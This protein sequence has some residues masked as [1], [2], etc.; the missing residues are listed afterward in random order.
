MRKFLIGLAVAA[1][2]VSAA[3]KDYDLE[4]VRIDDK[5]LIREWCQASWDNAV[6]GKPVDIAGLLEKYSYLS[7][8]PDLI[9]FIK[10]KRDEAKDPVERRR[11]HYFYRD[12]AT[13]Y[14]AKRVAALEDE[15]ENRSASDHIWVNGFDEPVTIR[16]YYFMTRETDD[17]D[18]YMDLYY[19]YYDYEINVMNPLRMRRLQVHY[20]S[21]RAAGYENYSDFYYQMLGYERG[22]PAAQAR[23][24]REE[25]FPLY[26]ELVTAR[27]RELYDKDPAETPPWE[28]KN[29]YWGKDFDEY[30]PKET[31]L[32][33]TYGFYAGMGMD[34]RTM[35]NVRVDD[36]DRPEKEP[37]AACW[38][39]DAPFD[40]R[41]NLKPVGGFDDYAAAFH[42]F[43]HALHG[44][45]TDP[46]L[47]YEFRMLGSNELTETYAI[48]FEQMFNDRGFLLDELGM[49]EDAIDEFLRYKLLLD[50]AVARSTAFD[51]YYDEPLHAG[52][53]EDPLAYYVA[54]VDK[55][56]LFPKYP[57]RDEGYY[58]VVDEGFYALYYMAA[59]YGVAQLRAAVVEKFGPKWY[60]DPAAGEFFQDL[61]SHGDEW[62]LTE[63]LQYVGYEE[64]LDPEYLVAEY[65]DRY[66]ASGGKK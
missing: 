16:D 59:F 32:D 11:L 61:F 13:T 3:A 53:L 6:Y 39:F 63:M 19:A 18:K 4:K 7:D 38:T 47:P 21:T 65:K 66:A 55:Q 36:E 25:T 60:K 27:C 17:P 12:L 14:E 64:G 62:T 45:N 57:V 8:D 29:I 37:R 5:E 10:E 56:R 23:K 20:D 2:A 41:V 43:G 51:V 31:F 9:A 24:F 46:D 28:S 34:I 54:E 49:P 1:L 26:K 35:P 40:V 33:F 42:E 22:V 30:F 44:G 15:M 58:L 52:E 48:F 50:M